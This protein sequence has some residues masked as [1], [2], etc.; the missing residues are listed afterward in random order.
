MFFTAR[1]ARGFAGAGAVLPAVVVGAAALHFIGIFSPGAL[2]HHNVQLTLT[3]AS[4]GLLIEAPERRWAAL[5]SGLCAA[6]TLAVGMETA[7]YVAAI[8][9]C[10][11]ILFVVDPGGE[12]RIAMDFGLGFAGVSALVFVTTI[13]PSGLGPGAMRCLL[14]HAVRGRG[15]CWNWPC[16]HRF[17]RCGQPHAPDDG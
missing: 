12:R 7:P 16:H 6:L 17:G 13:P 3:M 1:A 5:F 15:A 10:T 8:G 11:A 4:L 14:D 2:D 9:A